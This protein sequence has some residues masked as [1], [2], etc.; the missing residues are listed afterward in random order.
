VNIAPAPKNETSRFEG[1]EVLVA[2]DNPVNAKLVRKLL[3]DM[4][5]RTTLVDDGRKLV[6]AFEEG[7]WDLLLV[8][9]QMPEM[10]GLE[11]IRVIRADE[12]PGRRVPIL[13][14]TANAMSGDAV[15]CVEA[16]ADGYVGKPI[17]R[18]ELERQMRRALDRHSFMPAP[19]PG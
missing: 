1:L 14:V 4:G 3:A 8:D 13:V 11:A 5:V 6:R 19:V 12:P 10:D 16:G 2:E 15:T 7:E 17:R 18:A 9:W